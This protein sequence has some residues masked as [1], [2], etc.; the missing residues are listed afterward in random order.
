MPSTAFEETLFEALTDDAGAPG[1]LSP[2]AR[3]EEA[4]NFLR[5]AGA[6]SMTKLADGLVDPKLVLAWLLDHL[7][8]PAF[9]VGLLV[10]VREA[11][12]LL[13]QLL[14]APRVE[15]TAVRKWFWAAGSLVQGLAIGA[16]AMASLLLVGVAIGVAA[17]ILI[18]VFSVARSVCSVTVKDVLGKTVGKARRG[19]ATGLASSVAAAGVIVFALILMAGRGEREVVVLAA[20]TLA[21]ALW[22]AAA[23]L[24]ATMAEMP[25]DVGAHTRPTPILGQLGVLRRDEQLRLFI[26][27]R[28]L[29]TATALAP[30]YLVLMAGNAG[31]PAFT[32]LGALV[33]ASA[34]AALLSGYIWG[35]LADRSSRQVLML[36]GILAG[37]ALLAANLATAA[38][39]MAAAVTAPAILFMLMIA[40]HGVRS[41]RSTYL[42]DMAPADE[43]A[44]YT[45][46]SNTVIGAVLLG[47]GLFGAL[48]AIA[49]A[50][51]TIALFTAMSLGGAA[52][53]WFLEE[54]DAA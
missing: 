27:A 10:P 48:T 5:Q 11:G 22:L 9:F 4:G 31:G 33:L 49:G 41:G 45:A 39:G 54:V 38:G 43:R 50:G 28:G 42:V 40:Y 29:L 19:T 53:A 30:P 13:P 1:G 18:A 37:A 6:L 34:A 17:L 21:A 7:A 24:F 12:A 52:V 32:R 25:S 3:A 35:R 8:A 20:L 46:V 47:A 36:S 44:R 51:A 26:A 16:L 15:A 14:I 23:G 2:K